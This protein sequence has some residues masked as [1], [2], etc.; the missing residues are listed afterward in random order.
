MSLTGIDFLAQMIGEPI[1]AQLKETAPAVEHDMH[2][3]CC[4]RPSTEWLIP[5][6]Y[7][8]SEPYPG[9]K[10]TH[11]LSCHTLFASAPKYLGPGR[12]GK[13]GM[14]RGAGCLV[15]PSKKIIYGTGKHYE[16]FTNVEQSL[17]DEV[18]P[19]AGLACIGDA[20]AR[21]P[22]DEPFLLITDFGVKKAGLV[23]NLF[24]SEGPDRLCICSEK[25]HVW[26]KKSEV[27]TA[28]QLEGI[29]KQVL[30]SAKE[31]W[32]DLLLLRTRQY[33]TRAQVQLL[34]DHFKAYPA[35]AEATKQLPKD[36][37]AREFVLRITRKLI[38][39]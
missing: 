14:L 26:T 39:G 4:D 22:T 15:S 6:Y 19:L 1:I 21:I 16:R 7:E 10:E 27:I 25:D 37:H 29:P 17:F 28:D 30:S 23:K 24:V 13:L 3:D 12:T 31:G 2:C 9:S 35:L 34:A 38:E 33:L 32:I 20:L 36:P 8:T 5:D 11:C 18:V